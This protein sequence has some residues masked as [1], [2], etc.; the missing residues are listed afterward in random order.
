MLERD[1]GL[2]GARYRVPTRRMRERSTLDL[3]DGDPGVTPP[4]AARG[5]D[6]PREAR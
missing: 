4:R 5:I 3:G 1:D 6:A 2:P